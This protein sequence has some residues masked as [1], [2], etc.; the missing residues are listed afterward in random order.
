[1]GTTNP[2]Y[3]YCLL[4]IN[5]RRP[6]L[7]TEDVTPLTNP[8]TDRERR[9]NDLHTRTRSVVERAI[10]LLKGRWAAV[11]L[12]TSIFISD[13]FFLSSACVR[14]SEPTAL[15]A[16]HTLSHSLLFRLLLIPEDKLPN[17][18]T[19]RASTSVRRVSSSHSVNFR[20]LD[21]LILFL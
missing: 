6:W 13:H 2:V 19:L 3:L 10:G 1:M 4:S 9:Y 12:F 21:V 20:F 11:L 17:K 15:T 5:P 7:P 18:T 8:Q 16:S 14:L